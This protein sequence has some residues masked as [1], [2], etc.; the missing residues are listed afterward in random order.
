[1]Y[2]LQVIMCNIYIFD[3]LVIPLCTYIQHGELIN[4]GKQKDVFKI[5][6]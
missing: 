6:I 1:M 3:Y 5:L 4:L 2:W